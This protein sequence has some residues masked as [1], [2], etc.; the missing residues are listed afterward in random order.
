MAL[1]L[2]IVNA[3]GEAIVG[4][5]YVM[6]S[7]WLLL[8]YQ[9]GAGAL[10]PLHLVGLWLAAQVGRESG[11]LILYR[12][13]RFGAPSLV[14]LYR[15]LQ[16]RI[17]FINRLTNKTGTFNHR[18]NLL[19]PFSVAYGRLLGMRVPITLALAVK[20]KPQVLALGVLLSSIVWDAVYISV[21]AI[22]GSI[23]TVKPVYVLLASLAGL[24]V[25][26]VVIFLVRRLYKHFTAVNTPASERNKI[27]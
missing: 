13:A 24:T 7:V 10:S 8:G 15:K 27:S 19:S 21:G 11:A 16:Q 2:F 14:K 25:L 9:A 5:P 26:Y 4:L 6:E 17:G 3:F 12:V 18:V 1:F 23:V 22:F 20:R